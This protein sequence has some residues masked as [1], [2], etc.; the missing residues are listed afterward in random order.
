MN[1]EMNILEFV[2]VKLE[3]LS[4]AESVIHSS[5]TDIL[6]FLGHPFSSFRGPTKGF[7]N[8]PGNESGNENSRVLPEKLENLSGVARLETKIPFI[9]SHFL[10]FSFYFLLFPTI[11]YAK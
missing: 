5:K 10:L 1:L 4:G 3:N 11:S 9:P 7:G 6:E 8:E 2:G